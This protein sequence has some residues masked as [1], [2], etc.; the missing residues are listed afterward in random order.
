MYILT[1]EG[2][3]NEGA[4]SVVNECGEK[5]LYI[6]EDIDDAER[7]AM[8][9][10]ENDFPEISVVEVDDKLIVKTCEAYDYQY[11]IITPNDI[12]IPPDTDY[13]SI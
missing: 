8:M 3:E 9:L 1:V 4:Y 12:V 13:D 11:T 5:V 7:Y 6:F 10:E 2:R